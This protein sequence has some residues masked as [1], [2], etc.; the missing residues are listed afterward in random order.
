MK[1]DITVFEQA[2]AKARSNSLKIT[3]HFAEVP[4][5]SS[6]AELEALLSYQ[7]DRLG[8]VIHVPQKFKDVIA[9]RELGLELCLSCNVLAKL[10]EGGFAEHHF[11]DWRKTKCP[12][13]LSTDDVGIFDSPLSN[14]YL[15]AS[16]HFGL[17]AEELVALSKCAVRSTFGGDWQRERVLELIAAFEASMLE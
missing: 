10:T 14:E 7:P 12:I 13:A 2:F 1:G 4:Q 3:L 17:G 5:S 15:L 11:G 8:H 9:E 16:E 6:D